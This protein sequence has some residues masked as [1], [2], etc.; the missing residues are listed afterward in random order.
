MSDSLRPASV[1]GCFLIQPAA[2]FH[3]QN[4][5]DPIS[6]PSAP[7]LIMRR[8]T[9]DSRH[10]ECFTKALSTLTCKQKGS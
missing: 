4:E 9:G 10:T 2:C 8:P 1:F 7:A 6:Q 5:L 3:A